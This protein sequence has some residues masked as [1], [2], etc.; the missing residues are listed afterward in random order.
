VF[1]IISTFYLGFATGG[2]KDLLVS[3]ISAG[4]RLSGPDLDYVASIFGRSKKCLLYHRGSKAP[5]DNECVTRTLL[6]NKVGEE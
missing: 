4:N 3:N 5:V 1:K 2:V 6:G